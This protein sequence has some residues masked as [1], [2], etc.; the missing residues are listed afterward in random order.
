MFIFLCLR[1]DMDEKIATRTTVFLM[2]G[3]SLVSFSYLMLSG[4]LSS[5]VLPMWLCAAPIVA[6]GAPLGAVFCSWQKREH[7]V[8]FLILLILLEFI[9]TLW[10]VP[11]T[12]QAKVWA[13]VF[14]V[15]SGLFMLFIRQFRAEISVA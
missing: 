7:V 14:F 15:V 8:V 1:Y 10:L 13:G 4:T 12:F 2:A 6:F 11:F 5:E 9:S 3:V